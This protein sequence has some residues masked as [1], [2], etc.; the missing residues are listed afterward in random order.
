MEGTMRWVSAYVEHA[1]S[2]KGSESGAAV[3]ESAWTSVL[4]VIHGASEQ[5]ELYDRRTHEINERRAQI[6]RELQMLAS[7]GGRG[8][9]GEYTAVARLQLDSDKAQLV[10][11]LFSYVITTG[12]RWVP[13]YDVRVDTA[14]SSLNVVYH[15]EVTNESGEDWNDVT[16]TL[17]TA[18]PTQGA[19]P[20]Q[21]GTARVQFTRPNDEGYG[22]YADAKRAVKTAAS[23]QSNLFSLYMTPDAG[24][25]NDVVLAA[26]DVP[27]AFSDT[28]VLGAAVT[29]TRPVSVPAGTRAKRMLVGSFALDARFTYTITPRLSTTA[30]LKASVT[31]TS[32]Y[33][34]LPGRCQIF[35]DGRFMAYSEIQRAVA[36]QEDFALFLGPDQHIRVEY[37]APS[38]SKGQAGVILRSTVDSYR[39]SITVHNPKSSA[40]AVVVAEQLPLSN[41]ESIVVTLVEPKLRAQA[42]AEGATLTAENNIEWRTV[43]PA[44]GRASLPLHYTIDYPKSTAVTVTH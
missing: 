19:T 13:S 15:G 37:R 23:S 43:I 12:A 18:T 14:T 6:Q 36:Q 21:L 25:E 1:L 22:S 11:L 44:H 34:L 33:V 4:S 29:I 10:T 28:S 38:L 26:V 7:K 35:A 8:S 3:S 31:N 2:A 17:S 32:P 41:D 27:Q 9:E 20:P 5:R 42:G 16:L 30:F 39:G 24:M 40:I